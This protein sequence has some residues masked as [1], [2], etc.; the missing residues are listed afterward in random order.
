M[1]DYIS[2]ARSNYFHV[3]DDEQFEDFLDKYGVE[4]RKDDDGMYAMFPEE[5]WPSFS[6]YNDDTGDWEEVDFEGELGSHLA[7][8]SVAILQHIGHE[9]MRYLGGYSTAVRSDGE[10]L[11]VS[12]S[13]IYA[14]VKNEWNL[15]ATFA[16]Y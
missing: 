8:G 7:D 9:K 6:L 15:Q 2:Y 5:D 4:Y 1:A 14:R 13:D 12:I 11:S 10:V 3:K 16:E